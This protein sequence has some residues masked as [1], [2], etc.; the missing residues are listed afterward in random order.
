M[1]AYFYISDPIMGTTID[2]WDGD[3]LI[4]SIYV[5]NTS[6]SDLKLGLNVL[7]AKTLEEIESLIVLNSL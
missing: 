5:K 7:E 2:I 4:K 3:S 1:K 6:W